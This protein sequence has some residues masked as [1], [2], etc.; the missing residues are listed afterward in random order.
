MRMPCPGTAFQYRV[1]S[2]LVSGISNV[3]S[4]SW[5]DATF[6]VEGYYCVGTGLCTWS[7]PSR[8][9]TQCCLGYKVNSGRAHH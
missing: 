1:H 8:P 9:L 2:I 6:I 7:L 3:K 4:E 5:F